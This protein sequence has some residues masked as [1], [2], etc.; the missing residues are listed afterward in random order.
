M[1]YQV[2]QNIKQDQI[3]ISCEMKKK[4]YYKKI[5][6]TKRIETRLTRKAN[7]IG[8]KTIKE[9]LEHIAYTNN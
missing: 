9:Y 4:Y 3:K 8:I 6:L 7:D 5:H 1:E 2:E